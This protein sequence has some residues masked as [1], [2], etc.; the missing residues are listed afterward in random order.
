MSKAPK[1]Y[2]ESPMAFSLDEVKKCSQNR[3]YGCVETPPPLMNIPLD[4]IILDELHLLLRLTDVLL[5]N[6][7]KD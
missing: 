7:I 2:N 3:E 5:T 1:I 4:H 6:L